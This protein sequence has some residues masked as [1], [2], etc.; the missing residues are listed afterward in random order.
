[1]P[2]PLPL[3]W[4]KPQSAVMRVYSAVPSV[5]G[6]K[7][8]SVTANAPAT[9]VACRVVPHARRPVAAVPWTDALQEPPLVDTNFT[10]IEFGTAGVS[11]LLIKSVLAESDTRAFGV[12][13]HE[14]H[15]IS[16]SSGE[17]VYTLTQMLPPEAPLFEILNTESPTL[18]LLAYFTWKGESAETGF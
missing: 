6:V 18:R 12:T 16:C 1:M 14:Q 8:V 15:E 5:A 3:D 4:M 11:V 13:V 10:T 9:G 17:N 7:A 2:N